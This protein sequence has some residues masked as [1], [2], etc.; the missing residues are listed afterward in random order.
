M[1]TS[2]S[3]FL[4]QLCQRSI[5]LL[6]QLDFL[7]LTSLLQFQ[8]LLLMCTH[9]LLSVCLKFLHVFNLAID[10]PFDLFVPVYISMNVTVIIIEL[11]KVF[12]DN[13]SFT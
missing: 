7:C 2:R 3:V 10:E 5:Q 13:L 4:H 12:V 1:E 6:R 8:L 9:Q 11:T